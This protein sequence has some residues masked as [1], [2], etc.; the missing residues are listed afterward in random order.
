MISYID[1]KNI[2]L[3]FNDLEKNLISQ[4][5][6]LKIDNSLKTEIKEF[7]IINNLDN[8]QLRY[9]NFTTT[10]STYIDVKNGFNL[11]IYILPKEITIKKNNLSKKQ[12]FQNIEKLAIQ[13]FY[14]YK[15]LFPK[16]ELKFKQLTEYK[17]DSFLDLKIEF[18]I[19]KLNKLYNYLLNYKKETKTKIVCSD[20]IIGLKIDEMNY[21]EKNPL[22]IYQF[23]K[24]DYQ[25][26]LVIFIFNLMEF[27]KNKRLSIFKTHKKGKILTFIINKITNFLYKL[28]KPKKENL[29][30]LKSFFDKYKNSKE[31][32]KNKQIFLILEELFFNELD[33]GVLFFEVVDL[34]KM[35]EKVIEKRLSHYENLFIGDENA[36]KIYSSKTKQKLNI[37][38]KLLENKIPQYPDFMI[39]E[40]DVFH[41]IDAKYKLKKSLSREEY[42]Q[43]LI[44][45]KLFNK[46]SDIKKV[47]KL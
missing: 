6:S 31:L 32:K 37:N 19:D 24:E 13:I 44:Y 2:Y 8:N 36:K 22:K 38:N 20:K 43:I 21:Q 29:N 30:N 5:N 40:D 10:L 15:K 3:M 7:L 1:K 9:K 11:F 28:A 42:W 35:F 16:K 39:F 17:G 23:I 33:N 47:K 4:I 46:N 27:L 25:K 41:I 18:Y 14:L 45:A 12:F 26:D 34:S